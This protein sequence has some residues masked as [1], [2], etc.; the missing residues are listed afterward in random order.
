V[1]AKQTTWFIVLAAIAVLVIAL[2]PR[3]PAKAKSQRPN[4]HRNIIER[5]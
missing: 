4:V 2:F 5:L 1:I 3:N